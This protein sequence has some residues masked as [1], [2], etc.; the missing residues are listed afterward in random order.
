M[1]TI[2]AKIPLRDLVKDAVTVP[3]GVEY[4]PLIHWLIRGPG[5]QLGKF[6]NI[7]GYYAVDILNAIYL[8]SPTLIGLMHEMGLTKKPTA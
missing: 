4:L 5:R 7:E 6:R 8:E 3:A 2:E 1:K